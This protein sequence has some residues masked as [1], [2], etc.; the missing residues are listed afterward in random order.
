M[1]ILKQM[2]KSVQL[3]FMNHVLASVTEEK[4]H[5]KQAMRKRVVHVILLKPGS[6]ITSLGITENYGGTR[7]EPLF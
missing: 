2:P 3:P 1:V 7:H 4:E 6:F 5:I